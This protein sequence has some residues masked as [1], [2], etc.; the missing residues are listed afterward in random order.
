MP[1]PISSKKLIDSLE[2]IDLMNTLIDLPPLTQQAF[3]N[4]L[5]HHL[6]DNWHTKAHPDSTEY[7]LVT[8]IDNLITYYTTNLTDIKDPFVEL[9]PNVFL[10]RIDD[11]NDLLKIDAGNFYTQ[12]ELSNKLQRTLLDWL[13]TDQTTRTEFESYIVTHGFLTGH[14]L[15]DDRFSY[16]GMYESLPHTLKYVQENLTEFTVDIHE[17][18]IVRWLLIFIVNLYLLRHSAD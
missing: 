11:D 5:Q 2:N 16:N 7:A 15:K 14:D 17:S 8:N 10:F 9:A 12:L 4:I 13:K 3:Q 1:L 6:K 18:R